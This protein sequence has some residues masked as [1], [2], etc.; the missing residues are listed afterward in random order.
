MITWLS[1]SLL[2]IVVGSVLAFAVTVHNNTINIQTSGVILLLV[3]IFDLLLNFGL[4][5][6]LRQPLR[7]VDPYARAVAATQRSGVP[8]TTPRNAT[9]APGIAYPDRPAVDRSAYRER[10]VAYPDRADDG[11]NATRPIR[12]DDPNWH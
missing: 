6:Y 10:P 12:R 8:V 11:V 4:S 5:M 9:P 7:P 1:R 3:G 2:F